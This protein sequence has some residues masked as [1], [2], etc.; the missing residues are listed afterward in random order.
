MKRLLAIALGIC[1]LTACASIETVKEAKG[2]GSKV[3]NYPLNKVH[4]A[5]LSTA[6]KQELEI[7]E[8]N[9]SEG[10][11][12]LS[13]GVTLLSWGERIAVFLKRVSNGAT[14]VEIVS[15]PVMAPLN[16]PPD[17]VSLLFSGLDEELRPVK[18]RALMKGK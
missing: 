17:W 6:R 8:A 15:K 16:F 1:L 4:S 18:N 12:L 2:E 3:Y 9:E 5:T 10:R 7:L 14:E 13:H 11:V